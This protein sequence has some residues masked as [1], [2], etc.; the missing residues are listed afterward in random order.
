VGAD[1][2]VSTSTAETF[3]TRVSAAKQAYLERMWEPKVL[4]RGGIA[5]LWAP[6]DF[7]LD[8]KFSHCGIDTASFVKVA[9]AWKIASLSYTRET[10][11]C[12]VSPL[13]PVH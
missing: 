9:G 7:H 10:A 4:V 12:P 11:N 13:G 6:Y 1:G 3:V 2:K 8:G 5:V